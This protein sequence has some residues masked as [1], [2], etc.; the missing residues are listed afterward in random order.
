MKLRN[1]LNEEEDRNGKAL[2]SLSNE[3]VLNDSGIFNEVNKVLLTIVQSVN[4]YRLDSFIDKIY[5]DYAPFDFMPLYKLDFLKNLDDTVFHISIDSCGSQQINRLE[6]VLFDC[7]ASLVDDPLF[8]DFNQKFST[9]ATSMERSFTLIRG[10]ESCSKTVAQIIQEPAEEVWYTFAHGVRILN[11]AH[12]EYYNFKLPVWRTEFN[13]YYGGMA[14]LV[15]NFSKTSL[16]YHLLTPNTRHP[17]SSKT[18]TI[19]SSIVDG[20]LS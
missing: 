13:K 3:S 19:L 15:D 10:G 1:S 14:T 9:F 2:L 20:Y 11:Q 5:R 12:D 16:Q 4:V 6:N 7:E 18:K 8:K 17:P